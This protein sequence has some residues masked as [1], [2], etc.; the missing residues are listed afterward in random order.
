MTIRQSSEV[1]SYN[2][3]YWFT[4]P[5]NRIPSTSPVWYV[6]SGVKI[7]RC[8]PENVNFGSIFCNPLIS[9]PFPVYGVFLSS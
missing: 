9:I 1:Q 7:C 4:S 5:R 8:S 3:A 2:S 6:S